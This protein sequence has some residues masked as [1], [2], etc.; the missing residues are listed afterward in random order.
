M[1]KKRP[2]YLDL[3]KIRQPLP[4][5]ISILHRISGALL[6]FPG[7]PLVLCGLDM[8]LGSPEGYARFQS[9]LNNPMAKFGL[10]LALWFFLHH[11]CAGIRYLALDLHY[12]VKLEQAR[13]SSKVVVGAGIV[14]TLL[15][16]AV[17]W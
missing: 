12:G 1:P 15:T 4:A 14:L 2:K 5:V 9:L 13:L 3:L 7:I 10:I 16:G 11:F 17:I 6:F 8:A